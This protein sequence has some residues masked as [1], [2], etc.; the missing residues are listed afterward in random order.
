M[1]L[2]DSGEHQSLPEVKV[3]LV[4]GE[5]TGRNMAGNLIVQKDVFRVTRLKVSDITVFV[6]FS[7]RLSL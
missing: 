5:H 7:D 3:M 2:R 4:G 1:R 6:L